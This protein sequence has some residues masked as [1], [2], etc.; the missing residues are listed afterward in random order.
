MD[1]IC[2]RNFHQC[3]GMSNSGNPEYTIQ[4]IVITN[5]GQPPIVSVVFNRVAV[6]TTATTPR[7]RRILP[8]PLEPS[9]NSESSQNATQ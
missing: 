9:A 7:Y 8:R 1:S 5:T 4:T 2:C 3:G 6:S